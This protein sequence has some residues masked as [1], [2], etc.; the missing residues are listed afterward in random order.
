MAVVAGLLLLVV[1]PGFAQG[2]MARWMRPAMRSVGGVALLVGI[3]LLLMALAQARKRK[4]AGI[5]GQ[6][7]AQGDSSMI[8]GHHPSALEPVASAHDVNRDPVDANESAV[9]MARGAASAH[10]PSAHTGSVDL[11]ADK[12]ERRS[13][14]NAEPIHRS[15]SKSERDLADSPAWADTEFASPA[16]ADTEVLDHNNRAPAP[17]APT[18]PAAATAAAAPVS[19]AQD[20]QWDAAV[21]AKLDQQGF[22][23]VVRAMFAQAGFTSEVLPGNAA[24]GVDLRLQSR[25]NTTVR[26]TRCKQISNKPVG[27]TALREFFDT[28]TAQQT[29][30][31]TFATSSLFTAEAVRF[32]RANGIALLDSGALL[33]QIAKRT[34]EQQAA[35]LSLAQA[36][37]AGSASVHGIA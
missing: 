20:T 28:T 29:S 26:I 16:W 17:T 21:L 6:R 27:E 9:A 5:D 19:A 10:A 3:A 8:F 36:P 12:G 25:E 2:E 37:S 32:A 13:A 14:G 24:A 15:G 22:T 30:N 18:A 11:H 35:L 31:G 34:P 1:M 33:R 23:A 4:G 7:L